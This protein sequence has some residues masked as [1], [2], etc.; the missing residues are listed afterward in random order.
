[1]SPFEQSWVQRGG[2]AAVLLLAPVSVL[3]LSFTSGG[4]FPDATAVVTLVA[5][6]LLIVRVTTAPAPFAGLTPWLSVAAAALVSF[7]AWT[8]LSGTWSDS[9]SRALLEYNRVLLYATVFV[10]LG[11]LGRSTDRARVLLYGLAIATLTVSVAALLT[12]LLPEQL[13]A[14]GDLSRERQGWPTTYWNA[15][16][17]I[18]ALAVVWSAGITCSSTER[19]WI[20]VVAAGAA[21]LAAAA[22][23]FTVSRGA[24]AAGILGLLVAIVAT[25][26]R[27]TAGGLLALGPGIAA[28]VLIALGVEDLNTHHPRPEAVTA[29]ENAALVLAAV[30]LGS[31]ALRAVLILLDRRLSQAQLPAPRASLRWGAGLTAAVVVLATFL[32]LDGPARVSSASDRFFSTETQSV[33]GNLP[34]RERLGQLGNNGRIK[35]WEVAFE[36]GYESHPIHGSGAGTYPL[37]WTKH[38]DSPRRVLDAHSLYVEQLGELGIVGAVLLAVALGSMLVALVRRVVDPAGAAWG[39]LLAGVVT[40]LVHAGVDWDWEMPAVSVWVFAVGGLALS[41]PLGRHRLPSGRGLRIG[42]GV[43][44]LLLAVVPAL[45]WRSQ[46]RVTDAVMRLADGDC[47]TAR[48]AALDAS[49]ALPVRPEPFEVL[50]YCDAALGLYR[51][52]LGSIDAALHRDPQNWELYYAKALVR[53]SAGL[54]PRAAA[55]AALE[56]NPTYALT[57]E[58]VRG[59]ATDQPGEWRRFALRAPLPVPRR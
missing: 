54:D 8:L 44:C 1:M 5:L 37:L 30:A 46:T 41:A 52:A 29:G 9:P 51:P 40:W 14:G 26:S 56:R 38:G 45:V 6:L 27:S 59:F 21:P 42:V 31:A 2:L 49:A 12:W 39:A 19:A 23:I 50:A 7:A 58:A 33:A 13:P 18:A 22:L 15:T 20:R 3:V 24:A 36:D 48:D 43:G 35:Q 11:T 32:V 25:R 53:G 47:R 55:R 17:L 16:G 34:A 28:A 4:F 10:L 57:R